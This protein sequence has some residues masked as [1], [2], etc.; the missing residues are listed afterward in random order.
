MISNQNLFGEMWY[1]EVTFQT[2]KESTTEKSWNNRQ[3]CCLNY[4]FVEWVD[5]KTFRIFDQAVGQENR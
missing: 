3:K 5:I 1:I 2:T 4:H